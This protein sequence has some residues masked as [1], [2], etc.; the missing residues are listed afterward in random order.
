MPSEYTIQQGDTLLRIAKAHGFMRS[1][2]I[3]D[4]ECNAEFRALRPDPNIIY[5]GDIIKIP[6]KENQTQSR[7]ANG[8]HSFTV[9]KPETEMFRIVIQGDDGQAL[10]GKRAALTAGSETIDAPISADGLIEIELPNG[11]EAEAELKIFLDPDSEEPSHIYEVQLGHLDPVDTVSGVQARCNA[12]GFNTGV[13]DGVMGSNTREGIK[14]FQAQQG[15]QV[16]GEMTPET[17]D[18]LREVYGS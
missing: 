8:R 18:K 16:D 3:Y 17:L 5:P 13:V 6:D 7:P 11:D 4:H 15:L 2:S 12:L 14:D 1:E 10:E 9:K